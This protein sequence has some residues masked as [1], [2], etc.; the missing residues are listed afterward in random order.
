M[1]ILLRRVATSRT[2][3]ALV[4]GNSI[5]AGVIQQGAGGISRQQWHSQRMN[6][7]YVVE[8]IGKRWKSSAAGSE[9]ESIPISTE[10]N[11]PT[12]PSKPDTASA[13]QSRAAA[14]NASSVRSQPEVPS[15]SLESSDPSA[16]TRQRGDDSIPT[17]T[18]VP[19]APVV[20]PLPF[21]QRLG[22]LTSLINA[23][24]RAQRRSPLWTQFLSALVIYLC[25]DLSAQAIEGQDNGDNWLGRDWARTARNLVIGGIASVPGYH[26][27]AIPPLSFHF[28]LVLATNSKT[29]VH[30]PL[31]K[32]QLPEHNSQPP[33]QGR[34]QSARLRT[35]LQQLL[36]R[37]GMYPVRRFGLRHLGTDQ[38]HRSRLARQLVEDLAVCYC[39]QFS[40]CA[41][42][43]QSGVC[44]NRGDWLAELFELV[45]S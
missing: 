5:L 3:T 4:P 33:N 38:G 18:H 35:H 31:Q 26:W 11:N 19:P 8:R 45:E 44:G 25:G 9:S 23:Y 10:P 41:Y 12:T 29:Q 2:R 7:G 21:H 36:L 13:S 40:L 28:L 22:T 30:V 42:A 39:V 17:A 6:A 43:D 34:G 20:Q 16:S 1:S 37:H 15:P 32:L 27:W 24:D 14:Q